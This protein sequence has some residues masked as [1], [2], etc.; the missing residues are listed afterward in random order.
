MNDLQQQRNKLEGLVDNQIDSASGLAINC[1]NCVHCEIGSLCRY[2][3]CLKTGG[4]YCELVHRFPRIYEHLCRNHSSWSPRQ[5][6][7]LELLSDKIRKLLEWHLTN[8]HR[9]HLRV[10]FSVYNDLIHKKPMKPKYIIY[11]FLSLSFII[12]Y[13]YWLI[14]RD[15]KLFEAYNNPSPQEKLERNMIR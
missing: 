1:R 10:F 3:K 5:K 2:D 13:N 7:I 9:G 11:G 6:S 8:R 12:G 14:Q 4:E 15:Q